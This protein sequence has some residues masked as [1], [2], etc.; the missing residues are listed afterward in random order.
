MNGTCLCK[1]FAEMADDWQPLDFGGV[2]GILQSWLGRVV[3]VSVETGQPDT[4]L[5]LAHA[6]GVLRATGAI[7]DPQGY[8]EDEYPFELHPGGDHLSGFT[9]DRSWFSRRCSH[10]TRHAPDRHHGGSRGRARHRAT[11]LHR[12]PRS[13]DPLA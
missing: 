13:I 7:F 10:S 11:A 12:G 9:M 2:L 3:R 5:S 4:P 6:T 8:D 1:V